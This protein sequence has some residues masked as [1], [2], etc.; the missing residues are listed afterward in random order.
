MKI[1]ITGGTGFLG[2]ALAESLAQAGGPAVSTHAGH[3]V[4]SLSRVAGGT[5]KGVRHLSGASGYSEIDGAD[6]VVNLAGAGIADQRWTPARKAILLQSRVSVTRAVVESCTRAASKPKVLISGSAIGYY[7]SSLDARFDESSPAGAD[8]LAQLCANWEHEA[9]AVEALGIRCVLIRTGLVLGRT[10]G[11]LKK[12]APP[13]RMFAGGP[14]GSGRQWMSWIHLDDWIG[15][16]RLAITNDAVRGPLNLVAPAPVTNR[17][18]S[19]ALGRALHRPSVMPLPE[20]AVRLMFG[21][22]ADGTLLASQNVAPKV[23]REAGYQFRYSEVQQA[24][25]V[26]F[27]AASRLR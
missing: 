21:E 1:V 7:G 8:F 26:V 11:L 22:L 12:M 5:Y 10:G 17:E 25:N 6:A 2:S 20:F 9:R 14:V 24:L 16:V 4:V 18:F 15:L 3:D 23:A 19:H 13:F 27:S